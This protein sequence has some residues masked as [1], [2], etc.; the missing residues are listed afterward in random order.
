MN[1]L[2]AV[3]TG[4]RFSSAVM[5]IN[6]PVHKG[7]PNPAHGEFHVRGSIPAPCYNEARSESFLYDTEDA[8]IRALIAAGSTYIQGADCRK[9][10]PAAYLAAA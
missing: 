10:D 9:I 7:A 4:Q 1:L 6:Y 8:A 3:A 5:Q 2:T